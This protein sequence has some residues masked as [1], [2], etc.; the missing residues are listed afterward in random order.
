MKE[1]L[2]TRLDTFAASLQTTTAQLWQVLVNQAQIEAWENIL[3]N[4]IILGLFIFCCFVLNKN[5]KPASAADYEDSVSL[6]VIPLLS[7]IVAICMFIALMIQG[8]DWITMIY[9]PEYWAFEQIKGM[10]K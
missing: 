10:I 9:N 3:Q 4:L 1:E 7:F 5:F 8:T 6:A 2:L